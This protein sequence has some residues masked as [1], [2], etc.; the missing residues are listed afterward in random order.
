MS[1]YRLTETDVTVMRTADEAYIPNDPANI[2]WLEYQAW[3]DAGGVPDPY[4][5]PA[6]P[7]PSL[8][9]PEATDALLYDHENRLRNLEGKPPLSKVE[10]S[11]MIDR[12]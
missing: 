11:K 8:P 1:E 6:Q 4:I 2:D 9:K 10:F 7:E 12:G 5:P 3:L